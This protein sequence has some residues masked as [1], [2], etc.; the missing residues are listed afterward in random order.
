MSAQGF[1]DFV[2][3]QP[4]FWVAAA[5]AAVLAVGSLFAGLGRGRS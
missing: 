2:A 3:A 4:V 5:V 1:F